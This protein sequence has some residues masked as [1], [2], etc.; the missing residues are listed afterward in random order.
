MQN[1]HNSM[2]YTKIL[3]H[4]Q[5]GT[6]SEIVIL[7]HRLVTYMDHVKLAYILGVQQHG[8]TTPGELDF[9]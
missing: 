7:D 4:P 2:Q 8:M 1:A 9:M 6:S 5:R 3:T